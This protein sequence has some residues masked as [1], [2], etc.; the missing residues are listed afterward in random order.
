MTTCWFNFKS[1]IHLTIFVRSHDSSIP[2][3]Q[4]FTNFFIRSGMHSHVCQGAPRIFPTQTQPL[5]P[6]NAQNSSYFAHKS[7]NIQR[8]ADPQPDRIKNVYHEAL[9]R[10]NKF[11]GNSVHQ[12]VKIGCKLKLE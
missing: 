12:I 11:I 7:P 10:R 6:Q 5:T 4:L 9:T 3:S 2:A 1:H 8:L